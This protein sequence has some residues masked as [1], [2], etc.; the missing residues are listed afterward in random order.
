MCARTDDEVGFDSLLRDPLIRLV[1]ASDGVTEQDMIA[2]MGKLR[3]VMAAREGGVRAFT[4][5]RQTGSHRGPAT[6]GVAMFVA[7]HHRIGLMG[8]E[9]R[10]IVLSLW[11]GEPLLGTQ[12]SRTPIGRQQYNLPARAL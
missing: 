2:V 10:L 12:A 6:S 3:R 11:P 5:H 1:M 9:R 7:R 4:N 8:R